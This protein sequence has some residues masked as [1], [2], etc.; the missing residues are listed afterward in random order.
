MKP[1]TRTISI[2]TVTLLLSAAVASY[3]S[4]TCYW[5]VTAVTISGDAN[6]NQNQNTTNIYTCDSQAEN[7]TATCNLDT[8]PMHAFSTCSTNGSVT[9]ITQ[10]K[11]AVAPENGCDGDG[12]CIQTKHS[13]TQVKTTP[14]PSGS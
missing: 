10:K 8:L 5:M 1:I 6:C 14:C 11:N 12:A 2:M 4:N 9:W 13:D 7:G 3:A